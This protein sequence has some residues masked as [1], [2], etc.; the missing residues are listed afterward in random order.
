[1]GLP[2]SHYV[3]QAGF[4]TL[5]EDPVDVIAGILH[6][7]ISQPLKKFYFVDDGILVRTSELLDGNSDVEILLKT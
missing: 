6:I 5:F 4:A 1:M 7:W 3:R 2:K